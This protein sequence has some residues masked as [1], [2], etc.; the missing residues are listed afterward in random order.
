MRQRA[1]LAQAIVADPA[2]VLLDEPTAGLDP[3]GRDEMLALVARLGTFGISAILATHILDD[4]QQVCSHV[5]MLD[6]GRLVVS[7][8]TQG[9]TETTGVASVD[10][11]VDAAL[12]ATALVRR[13]LVANVVDG[14][15]E[16][17]VSGQGDLDKVRD[18]IAK[19]KLPLHR[20][21]ARR[22]SLDEVFLAGAPGAPAP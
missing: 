17:R 3:T 6:G 13:K 7:G 10:V 12:L 5:V 22:H 8:P 4:V 14:Y 21:T 16:V 11:G 2:L 1:K 18:E 20:L 15:V 9:L 19:L